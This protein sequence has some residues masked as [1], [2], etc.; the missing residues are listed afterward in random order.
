MIIFIVILFLL[1]LLVNNSLTGRRKY[2]FKIWSLVTFILYIMSVP[3]IKFNLSYGYNKKNS[4]NN[5]P[6][7]IED[8]NLFR[9]LL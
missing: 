3:L 9:V 7:E 5:L 6:F 1:L 4:N 2:N 8:D